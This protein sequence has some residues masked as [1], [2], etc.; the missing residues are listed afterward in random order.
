MT[1]SQQRHARRLA[2]HAACL[3]KRREQPYRSAQ[4]WAQEL[5]FGLDI[6]THG[7]IDLECEIAQFF[8][9]EYTY[10]LELV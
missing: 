4:W 1:Y 6:I 7:E 9:A 10:Q 2:I 5:C 3:V 8:M